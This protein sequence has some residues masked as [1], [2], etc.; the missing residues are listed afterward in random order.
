MSIEVALF[1]FIAILALHAVGLVDAGRLGIMFLI[2]HL[3]C[4][5]ACEE[6][7][8]KKFNDDYCP[9]FWLAIGCI[10][11]GIVFRIS[12]PELEWRFPVSRCQKWVS[13]ELAQDDHEKWVSKP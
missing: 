12:M 5:F 13:S 9:F 10:A 8:I 6:E 11:V 7:E 3:V 1:S 4:L 2:F